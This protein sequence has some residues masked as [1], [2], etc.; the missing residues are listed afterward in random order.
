V[1]C[2][3]KITK[4]Q[5]LMP[6][7]EKIMRRPRP[8]VLI[9][10]NV[11][12]AAL[13]M[14]VHNHVNG[15]FQCVATK[16]PGFGDRRLRKLEDI[17]TITGGTVISKHSNATVE[18]IQVEQLGRARQVRVTVPSWAAPPSASTRTSSTNGSARCPARWRSSGWARPRTRS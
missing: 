8:M 3:E 2:A 17:A 5:E 13:S 7:L 10:E 16:A 4:V 6:L 14:L 1:L 11:E 12:G 15:T 9:A 18:N